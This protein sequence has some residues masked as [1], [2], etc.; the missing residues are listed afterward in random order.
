MDRPNVVLTTPAAA[1]RPLRPAA[2]RPVAAKDTSVGALLLDAGKLRPEDAERVVRLARG[3]GLRFGEAAVKLG[4]VTQ[5]DIQRVLS[6]QF[7]Y[8]YLADGERTPIS[9]ELIAAYQPFSPQVEALRALR[10]QLLLRLFNAEDTPGKILAIASP[11]RGDGRSYLAANLAIVFS[12]LGERT[13]LIDADMRF[14]R[15]HTLFNLSGSIGLSSLLAGRGNGSAIERVAAFLD[16]SVLGAGPPPPN[17]QELLSRANFGE[18]LQEFARSFDVVLIDTPAATLS[19]DA[20]AIVGR[21]GAAILVARQH[22]TRIA[23]L[24]ALGEALAGVR[25]VGSVLNKF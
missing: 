21:A 20:N 13:L 12:Q 8:P 11:A 1:E 9:R 23:E 22:R 18:L 14:P 25:L 2:E 10:G 3:E 19:A 6:R 24:S 7:H 5:A 4:L 16:L 17:P 15:Q